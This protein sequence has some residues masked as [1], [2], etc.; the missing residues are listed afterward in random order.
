MSCPECEIQI[1]P[2]SLTRH[3]SKVHNNKQFHEIS[4]NSDEKFREIDV[5]DDQD[6]I[7]C[8]I[9]PEDL[10]NSMHDDDDEEEPEKEVQDARTGYPV[11]QGPPNV[12]VNVYD[13]HEMPSVTEVCENFDLNNVDVEYTDDDFQNLTTYKIYQ[14]KIN[15]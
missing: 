1:H 2:N 13:N 5:Q 9:N 4:K 12:F 15:S 11:G 8:E 10:L 3:I 6:E 14:V 7:T